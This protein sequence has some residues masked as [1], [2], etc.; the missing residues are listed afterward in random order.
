M[1]DRPDTT[2]IGSYPTE[3]KNLEF[4]DKYYQNKQISWEKYIKNAVDDMVNAG[5]NIISD[6]QTRDPFVN[7][8][9]R[10]IKG[11]R[12]RARPE[13]IDQVEFEKPITVGDIKYVKKIAPK[14]TKIVG[15]LAGPYTLAKSCVDMYYHDEKALS[16]DIAKV[17]QKEA[18]LLQNHVDLISVDEPFFSISMPDY[19][20]DL[21]KIVTR[22]VKCK[23]RLHV[24]GDVSTIIPILLDMPVD[25]LSH[26]FKAQPKLFKHF[27]EHSITK[28]ICLGCIRSDKKRV[29]STKEIKNHILKGKDVFDGKIGQLAPDCGLRHIPKENAFKKLVNLVKA[30]EEVYG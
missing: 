30:G 15:L 29:E 5:I 4:I 9:L 7:I 21:I 16:F 17:L 27:K 23:K 3:I 22:K 20:N 12:I 6:G 14:K 13:V 1:P 10:K 8:Y 25:I 18:E 24:C 19:A 26:E 2:V 28:E 11:C